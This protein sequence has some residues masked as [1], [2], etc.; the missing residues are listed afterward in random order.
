MQVKTLVWILL[1]SLVLTVSGSYE[2]NYPSEDNYST[3]EFPDMSNQFLNSSSIP[4]SP[5]AEVNREEITNYTATIDFD[6]ETS[7]YSVEESIG[8]RNPQ[9]ELSVIPINHWLLS[10]Q[11]DFL[12]ASEENDRSIYPNGFDDIFLQY[13]N[14]SVNGYPVNYSIVSSHLE[15]FLN[16]TDIGYIAKGE[17]VNV[18]I[19]FNADVPN[20]AR[21]YAKLIGEDGSIV[22]AMPHIL[23]LLPVFENDQ[24]RADPFDFRG[25]PFYSETA[26]FSI[27]VVTPEDF[28]YGATGRI[29]SEQVTNGNRTRVY[30]AYPVRDWAMVGSQ[31]YELTATNVSLPS[32]REVSIKSFYLNGDS[33]FG[34]QQKRYAVES[35]NFF[36]RETGVEYPYDDYVLAQVV[37][38]FYGGMEYPQLVL[39]AASSSG[40]V[41]HE[42]AHQWNWG[43]VGMDQPHETWLDEGLASFWTDEFH[44]YD[45]TETRQSLGNQYNKAYIKD[46]QQSEDIINHTIYDSSNYV[47]MSYYK[48]PAVLHDLQHLIGDN[49][50][51]LILKNFYR[52]NRFG[53]G[54]STELID[55]FAQSLNGN[56]IYDYFD[57]FLNTREI[58]HYK[59]KISVL[60]SNSTYT[61]VQVNFTDFWQG[62]PQRIELDTSAFSTP[63]EESILVDG[64]ISVIW[65]V[66]SPYFEDF[67]FD[68]LR[69]NFATYNQRYY[70][71]PPLYPS[72]PSTGITTTVE[73]TMTTDF[74]TSKPSESRLAIQSSILISSTIVITFA[75]RKKK[76]FSAQ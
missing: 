46:F 39:N 66:E 16:S 28:V 69:Q 11:D 40:V 55:E 58:P 51:K 52:E 18:S 1:I 63:F 17:I 24:W 22:Y 75:S 57:R 14:I 21:R 53:I 29:V 20:S 27:E 41:V 76:Y 6:P 32:G 15:L 10:F 65:D 38:V 19:S 70:Y 54:K 8:F 2:R 59:T 23:P 12:A 25:E 26:F 73:D 47:L 68:P 67:Y 33:V 4:L 37:S 72:E 3:A 50:F 56:W 64:N 31:N 44:V 49:L 45:G 34:T 5:L 48:M 60:R 62:V 35:I 7:N 43:I 9:D 13:G 30:E 74:S 36:S 42:T 71:I 61:T